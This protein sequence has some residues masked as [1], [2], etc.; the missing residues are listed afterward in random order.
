MVQFLKRNVYFITALL[1][2]IASGITIADIIIGMNSTRIPISPQDYFAIFDKSTLMGLYYL[3]FLNYINLYFIV[4]YSCILLALTYKYSKIAV[5]I[6][7]VLIIV[8]SIFFISHNVSIEMSVLSKSYLNTDD[9]QL[10]SDLVNQGVALLE[11]GEHGSKS[12]FT[13]YFILAITN[14]IISILMFLHNFMNKKYT[15]FGFIGYLILVFYLIYI[16]FIGNLDDIVMLFV[17]IG[18]IFV[19]VWQIKLGFILV[20]KHNAFIE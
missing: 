14:V 12:A 9:A 16:T 18:G 2:F 10:K 20:K 1:L 6:T 8:G 19:L 4:G 3:D 7:I 11:Y 17:A 15:V 13:G 5:L